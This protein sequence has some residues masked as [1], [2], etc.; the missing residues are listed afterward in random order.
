M[1]TEPPAQTE[2]NILYISPWET[3]G[4][5]ATYS[6]YLVPHLRENSNIELFPWDYDTFYKRGLGIPFINIEFINN[7]WEADIVHTQY[8][9]SLYFLSLP[10]L[11]LLSWITRTKMVL[12]QHERFGN[13]PMSDLVFIYHQIIYFFIDQVIVHT[14]H[15][16]EL[17]WSVHHSR[18]SVIEHGI[19]NRPDFD[20]SPASIDRILFPG[21]IR[22]SKGHHLVIRALTQIDGVNLR[23]VG[24]ISN[25]EY[26]NYLR[27]VSNNLEINDRIQWV[28]QFVPEE[29]L[30]QELQI[31]DLVILP[32]EK[33]TAMSGILCHC[34]SWQIPTILSDAPAFRHMVSCEDV[35]LKERSIETI[36]EQIQ[37][38][39]SDI[40]KQECV[41]N[42]FKKISSNYSWEK[43]AEDTNHV[44]SAVLNR[45]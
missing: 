34:I 25:A 35:Y 3:E 14:N 43:V 30:F 37:E 12:T 18:V 23:I 39:D 29:Q 2:L 31:A 15:R 1:S 27:E 8:T 11:I 5:I 28:T 33:E 10:I 20:R 42:E 21:A 32:Y 22:N 6:H 44:Y 19:I 16:K 41:I 24:G 40:R 9:P 7:L 26:F 36:V 13:L 4:G 38:F 17:I 45:C